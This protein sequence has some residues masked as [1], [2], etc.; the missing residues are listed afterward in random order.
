MKKEDVKVTLENGVITTS[1]ER[2]HEKEQKDTNEIRVESFYGTFSRSQAA[3]LMRK[4]PVGFLV[5]YQDGDELL[6][7]IGVL[8]DRDLVLAVMARAVNPHSVTIQDVMW[9]TPWARWSVFSPST[10]PSPSS[11]A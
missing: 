10:M 11:R 7:P 1:G 9:W 8:T 3:K 4:E 2:R 5:V 6:E